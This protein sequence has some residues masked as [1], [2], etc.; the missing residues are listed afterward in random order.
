[1]AVNHHVFLDVLSTLKTRGWCKFIRHDKDGKSCLLGGFE[2]AGD[3]TCSA[4][5]QFPE[6]IEH[7]AKVIRE[8]EPPDIF[9]GNSWTIAHFNNEPETT[10]EMIEEVL[11]KAAEH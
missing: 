5:R 11:L 1:M 7:L 8:N 9:V 3:K 2:L 6:E 4:E 10:F